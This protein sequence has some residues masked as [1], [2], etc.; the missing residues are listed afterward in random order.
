MYIRNMTWWMFLW[1]LISL[2]MVI[3]DICL[4][5]WIFG[6]NLIHRQFTE[7]MNE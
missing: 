5:Q 4:V 7:I 3:M 6:T 1:C 2:S